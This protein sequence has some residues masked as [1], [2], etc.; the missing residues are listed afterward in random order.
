MG[1]KEE[2]IH[3][4]IHLEIY[5][6]VNRYLCNAF[7]SMCENRHLCNGSKVCVLD[8]PSMMG[9]IGLWGKKWG[10]SLSGGCGGVEK[11][12][13]IDTYICISMEYF[14]IYV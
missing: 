1:E 5:M 13:D 10:V 11:K 14:Q 2:N 12:A 9:S 3:T 8:G 4:Y 7:I 6:D